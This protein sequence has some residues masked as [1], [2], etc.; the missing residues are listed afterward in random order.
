MYHYVKQAILTSAAAACMLGATETLFG[1]DQTWKGTTNSVLSTG[2]NWSGG[3][4]PGASFTG[5]FDGTNV[6]G[7][8]SPTLAT[9]FSIKNMKFTGNFTY[10]F[11]LNSGAVF[12]LA[13]SAVGDGMQN[14]S[15]PTQ[16]QFFTLVAGSALNISSQASAS[17]GPGTLSYNMSSITLPTAI[18]FTNGLGGNASFSMTGSMANI[19]FNSAS[20][21]QN[22]TFNASSGS[23]ITFAGSSNLNNASISLSGTGN[24]TINTSV[25]TST[26]N[27]TMTGG[28]NNLKVLL[29]ITLASVDSDDPSDVIDIQSGST[30]TLNTPFTHTITG[31]I[32]NSIGS[33][34]FIKDGGVLH[35]TNPNNNYSGGTSILNGGTLYATFDS[36]STNG[37][38]TVGSGSSLA[39]TTTSATTNYTGS[40]IDNGQVFYSVAADG[41]FSGQIIG[42]GKLIMASGNTLQ[43]TNIN[44]SYSG[45]TQIQQGTLVVGTN[46][47]P[48]ASPSF[49]VLIFLNK[50]LIFNLASTATY[51]GTIFNSGTIS[52]TAPSSAEISGLISGGGNLVMNSSG[53]VLKLS[54]TSNTYSGGTTVTAG[55]LL[56]GPSSLPSTPSTA[57]TVASGA[58]LKFGLASGTYAGHIVDNGTLQ[59][60]SPSTVTFTG[61]ISGS[62]QVTIDSGA[63]AVYMGAN[64]YNG[65][66]TISGELDVST[67]TLP[68]SSNVLVNSGGTLNFN[69][70][71]NGTYI[72]NITDNGTVK[73]GGNTTVTFSMGTITGS[74]AFG[75]DAGSTAIFLS[76]QKLYMGNTNISGLLQTD[77]AFLPNNSTIQFVPGGILDLTTQSNNTFSGNILGPGGQ[78]I[79]DGGADQT[80]TGTNSYTEKTIVNS[81]TLTVGINSLPFATV[82]PSAIVNN[83]STLNMNDTSVGSFN[84]DI[85]LTNNGSLLQTDNPNLV[86]NGAI[87]GAGHVVVNSG[88]TILNS[89]S[90]TYG[91]GDI[92]GTLVNNNAT[93]IASSFTLPPSAIID[94]EGNLVFN[95]QTNGIFS[96]SIFSFNSGSNI[97]KQGNAILTLT[98]DNSGFQGLTTVQQG[99]LNL[100]SVLGGNVQVDTSTTLTGTGEIT[101]NLTVDGTISPGNSIGKI[102]VDETYS[103]SSSGNYIVEINSAGQSD[104]IVVES[105]ASLAGTVT[106]IS[107]D[108]VVNTSIS[109]LIMTIG[110]TRS[111]TFDN[112]VFSSLDPLISAQVFYFVVGST[113]DVVLKFVNVLETIPGLTY[114]QQQVINQIS[115]QPRPPALVPIILELASLVSSADTIGQAS[116][117]LNQMSG[118]Q[119]TNLGVIAEISGHQLLQRLY[120][121]L[122]S[123]VTTRPCWQS[124]CCG[125]PCPTLDT[126]IEAG[127][128][129]T[130]VSGNANTA[131]FNINTYEI[132]AGAQ[133]T[134]ARNVTVGLAGSYVHDQVDYHIGGSG[135]NHTG[136]GGLYALYRPSCWYALCDFAFGCIDTKIKRPITIGNLFYKA[137]SSPK[138]W[139]VLSYAEAGIDCQ[140]RYFL[141]QPF[142][143]LETGYYNRNDIH[144]HGAGILNLDV[145]SKKHRNVFGRIGAH[146]TTH[147][148]PNNFSLSFD[149]AWQYRFTGLGNTNQ[150]AFQDF[151]S[152]FRIKGLHFERSSLDVAATLSTTICDNLIL[153]AEMSGERWARAST[154]NFTGGVKYSF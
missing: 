151:G 96:G 88:T 70:S 145:L 33:G 47:L 82:Q 27:V 51:S 46:T 42:L 30:L 22:A 63:T 84:G 109:Y 6:A 124:C 65:Q 69:Q 68:S 132:T 86:L 29:P 141:F 76:P 7:T 147:C 93:L 128:G 115:S 34:T 130:F 119:Y 58:L 19:S 142:I 89:T 8:F 92:P 118:Q 20:D 12:N 32:T 117:A 144:E 81:G 21:A 101:G 150:Q 114:N 83:T 44:N 43:L 31:Q 80:L 112:V 129:R 26:A 71:P 140:W 77:G 36:L 103:Q 95:Q 66:T 11:M 116:L 1:A 154:Y 17:T 57:A 102:T 91:A 153:Y 138:V 139:Q 50:N 62:G 75:V 146:I 24:L 13:G 55:T 126:W 59:I 78:V 125:V 54:N 72:G 9:T 25:T 90:N 127:G 105:N 85:V 10:S 28:S 38:S 123:I 148:L 149:I 37:L 135:R 16:T 133:S 61:I 14:L 120:D 45:G 5:T 104:L 52:Y 113:T 2:T 73:V 41:T 39:F 107:L 15:S 111:G 53:Q 40:I 64:T 79:M 56:V 134:F 97:T 131:G 74:G 137:Q 100:Q 152:C 106:V 49:P 3:A 108:G 143:G 98:G 60:S 48:P 35:I 122:R 99:V 110:G 121:P 23:S 87:S 18:S 136:Y 94:D 4:V 67:S